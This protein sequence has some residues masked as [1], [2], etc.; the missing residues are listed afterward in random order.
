[1]ISIGEVVVACHVAL[2]LGL[3]AYRASI[4]AETSA[5]HRETSEPEK[6]GWSSHDEEDRDG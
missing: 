1:M 2:V 5:A 6:G 4:A 3:V